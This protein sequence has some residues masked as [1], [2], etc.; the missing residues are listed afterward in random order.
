MKA[1]RQKGVKHQEEEQ[2]PKTIEALRWTSNMVRK[3]F[4]HMMMMR[5]KLRQIGTHKTPR[6]HILSLGDREFDHVDD[7]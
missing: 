4:P 7:P 1:N 5:P 6:S 3:E 2:R